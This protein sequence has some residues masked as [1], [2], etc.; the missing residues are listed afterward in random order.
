MLV[1]SH[2][3]HFYRTKVKINILFYSDK[4]SKNEEAKTFEPPLL[5]N[6]F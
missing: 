6:P 2:L 3:F 5:F 1:S 4:N